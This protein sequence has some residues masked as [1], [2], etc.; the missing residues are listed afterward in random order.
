MLF[1]QNGQRNIMSH[2]AGGFHPVLR[3]RKNF[4]PHV[5][6]GIPKHLIQLI[7]HL[8]RML[9]NLLIGNLQ[10]F[11]IEKMLIQ[12]LAVGTAAGIILLALL[13]GN[14]PLLDRID[15]QNAARLKP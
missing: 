5:L 3:H 6:V 13:I 11:Q 4:V 9:R 8:L 12:P 1:R 15:Q 10:I 2:G 14:D 7:P